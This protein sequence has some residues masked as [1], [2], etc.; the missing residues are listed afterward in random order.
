MC[1]EIKTV[2][3]GNCSAKGWLGVGEHFVEI[4]QEEFRFPFS[5]D[6]YWINQ[7]PPVMKLSASF[8]SLAFKR[9]RVSMCDNS[10]CDRILPSMQRTCAAFISIY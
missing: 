5:N 3:R 4:S 6:F 2:K 1:M 8:L 7:G 10:M 9:S